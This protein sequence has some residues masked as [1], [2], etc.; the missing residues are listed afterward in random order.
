M[1]GRRTPPFR[2]DHVGSLLRPPELK[3]AREGHDRGELSAAGL[4][5]VE[6]RCIR[7]VVARQEEAGLPA[8]TDGEF[9]RY[10]FHTPILTRIR[11][12][13]LTGRVEFRFHHGDQDIEYAP[14]VL[15]VRG[16]LDRPP[17]GLVI[18]DVR[19]TRGLTRRTVK[20]TLPSPTY[21]Y[22]RGGWAGINR[23]VYPTKEALIADLAR[24]YEAELQALWE[25]G[26]TFVQID[27]TNFAHICDPKFRDRYRTIGEDPDTLPAFYVRMI[28]ECIRRRPPGQVVG[29]HMCRG[30]VRGAWVA[31][32]G[33]EHVAEALLGQLEV[34]CYFLEYDDE[35]SGDFAPLRHLRKG[36]SV[37][38]LGLV[39]T[40]RP[41]LE[42]PDLLRRRLDEAARYV[43]LDR[44]ALSPQ[45][46]FA[47]IYHGNPL[48]IEQQQA[49]LRHVVEVAR[50]VWG[51]L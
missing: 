45:C 10:E 39:T 22:A 33:Y 6:D 49:K 9:R 12:V 30:N 5:A 14:P 8:I 27:D 34:D 29:I 2:A 28:N 40:K 16:R 11:G 25:A 18:E 31:A 36:D 4:R 3:E 48:T 37:V 13:E 38:V 43:P 26:C 24:V 51:E 47:S 42:P 50:A 23:A 15:E 1:T 20:A 32:G 21:V 7:D 41:P 19:F 17:E 44:L 46:G 35:R